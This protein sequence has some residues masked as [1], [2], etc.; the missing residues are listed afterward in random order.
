MNELFKIFKLNAEDAKKIAAST[1]EPQ[2]H[3]YEELLVGVEGQMEHFIDF[4]EVKF[5]AP[6]ISFIT[7]GKLHRVKPAIIKGKCGI[8]VMRFSPEIIPETTFRLYAYY[9]DHANI[10]M[11][12]DHCFRRMVTLCEMMNDEMHQPK[13]SL[14]LVR[15]LLKTLFTMI[16]VE[17]EKYIVESRSIPITK[18]TTFKNFL[19]ILEENYRRPEGVE[20]Y[21]EK[22]FM[23]ARN[24]NLIC[25]NILR[26]SISEIIEI[27]KLIEAKNLLINSDKTIS[28]IGFELGYNEKAYFTSVFKKK[29]GQ[30]PSEFRDDMS[31]LIT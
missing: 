30:T 29:I 27:R 19:R 20:F 31:K 6:F 2:I 23:S 17:R 11:K 3:D 18:S 9:H 22:L 10:E 1:N 21:A 26:K 28:E 4:E 12:N 16:D 24:L 14:A 5:T 25:R 13:P 7:K 8:W 15:D